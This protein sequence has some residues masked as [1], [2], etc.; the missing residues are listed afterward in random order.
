MAHVEEY[1]SIEELKSSVPI[2]TRLTMEE[3]LIKVLDLMD[4]YASINKNIHYTSEEDGIDWVEL[5]WPAN[6]QPLKSKA[7]D[8]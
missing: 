8:H 6:D 4:L 7:N 3:A 5:K 1:K 2:G